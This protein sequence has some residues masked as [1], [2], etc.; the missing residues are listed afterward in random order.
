MIKKIFLVP[1]LLASALVAMEDPVEPGMTVLSECEDVAPFI[2]RV[3]AFKLPWNGFCCNDDS[4]FQIRERKDLGYA[5]IDSKT[6]SERHNWFLPVTNTNHNV[7]FFITLST[8]LLAQGP[9]M[10]RLARPNEID[11]F[12]KA[13]RAGPAKIDILKQ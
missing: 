1:L 3:V 7:L 10:L 12:R 4:L 13:I 6:R 11:V 2:D 8:A 9:L 5:Y